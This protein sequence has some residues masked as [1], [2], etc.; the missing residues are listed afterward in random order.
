MR[1]DV[2]ESRSSRFFFV[3]FSVGVDGSHLI[4]GTDFLV[5]YQQTKTR[6]KKL[7]QL[8]AIINRLRLI[9]PQSTVTIST[10]D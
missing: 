6:W 5:G 8:I 10:I 3:V 2:N 7:T 1:D 4:F 9:D